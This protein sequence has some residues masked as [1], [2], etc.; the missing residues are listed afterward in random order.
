MELTLKEMIPKQG[1]IVFLVDAISSIDKKL[2]NFLIVASFIE[3]YT[4]TASTDAIITLS[5]FISNY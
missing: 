2:T 1:S 3:G 5:L 4:L